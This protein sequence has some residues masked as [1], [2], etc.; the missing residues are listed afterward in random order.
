MEAG[1]AQQ[2]ALRAQLVDKQAQAKLAALVFERQSRLK[3]EKATSDETHESS[4]AA[5]RSTTAQVDMLQ[6]QIVQTELTL[7]GDEAT[8]DTRNFC[9]MSGTIASLTARKGQT[10]IASQ[11]APILLRIRTSQR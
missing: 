2:A 8:L 9:P 10:L 11:Q 7:R 5:M 4:E 6:A 1:R 3:R